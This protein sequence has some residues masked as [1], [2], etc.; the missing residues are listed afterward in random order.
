MVSDV[1]IGFV[2]QSYKVVEGE[3]EV[4]LEVRVREGEIPVDQ[5]VEVTLTTTD[6]SANGVL[7]Y[8]LSI[9]IRAY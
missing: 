8:K 9:R 2:Q 4:T 3:G 1:T 5:N 6:Q 7:F